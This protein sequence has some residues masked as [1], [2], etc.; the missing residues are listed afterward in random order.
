MMM[1]RNNSD[2]GF[3][4]SKS[5]F[6]FKRKPQD[7]I[8]LEHPLQKVKKEDNKENKENT[9]PIKIIL[10]DTILPKELTENLQDVMPRLTENQMSK[11]KKIVMNGKQKESVP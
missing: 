1:I 5:G 6:T 7:N 4:K 9:Q 2:E 8:I 3:V 10:R 11:D